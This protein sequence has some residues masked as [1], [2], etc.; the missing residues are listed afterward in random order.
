[1]SLL[2]VWQAT[3]RRDPAAPAIY[4]SDR[5]WSR[6]ELD[7]LAR[8]WSALGTTRSTSLLHRALFFSEP[9]GPLWFERFLGILYLGAVPA[10]LDPGEPPAAQRALARSAGAAGFATAMA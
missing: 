4:H 5:V 9:N 1:M 3:V 2:S 8:R 7:E 6:K 10:P